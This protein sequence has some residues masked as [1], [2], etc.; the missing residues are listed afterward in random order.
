HDCR[1]RREV[2]PDLCCEKPGKARLAGPRRTPQQERGEVP[3]G[4][5]PPERTAF[6]DEVL[7][8]DEFVE[9]PRTHPRSEWLPLGRRLEQGLGSGAERTPRGWHV[10]DGS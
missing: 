5:A 6:T 1:H 2:R 4:D 8:A 9:G 10:R 3:A 7:L